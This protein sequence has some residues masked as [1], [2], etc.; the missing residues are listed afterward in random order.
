M[1]H[2]KLRKSEEEFS[3]FLVQDDRYDTKKVKEIE[4]KSN[5]IKK[6]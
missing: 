3:A 1:T 4:R 6:V 5:P 2:G